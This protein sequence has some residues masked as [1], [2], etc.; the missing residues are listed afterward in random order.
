[1]FT[2]LCG[3]SLVGT[4][5]GA[6][7]KTFR[8]KWHLAIYLISYRPK[9]GIKNRPNF[10]PM[11][12]DR[13]CST[14][15]KP[16]PCRQNS[17]RVNKICRDGCA[18]TSPT[19]TAAAVGDA[20]FEVKRGEKPVACSWCHMQVPTTRHHLS[21]ECG[22]GFCSSNAA[23]GGVSGFGLKK[24]DAILQNRVVVRNS[25]LERNHTRFE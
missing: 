10:R 21:W 23:A 12:M 24:N 5:Q 4:L 9:Q 3:M 16:D 13:A 18:N 6:Y 15:S 7:V 22:S 25:V 1:M 8:Q 19:L 20:R 2:L 11:D 14:A 17:E